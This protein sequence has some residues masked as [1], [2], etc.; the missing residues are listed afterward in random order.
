[1]IKFHMNLPVGPL[2]VRCSMVINRNGS[3][4]GLYRLG[5]ASGAAKFRNFRV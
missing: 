4:M 2:I 3:L 1:M 5:A